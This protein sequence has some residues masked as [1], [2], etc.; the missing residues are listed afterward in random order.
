MDGNVPAKPE[1]GCLQAPVCVRCWL[2]GMPF[3]NGIISQM[4]NR[5]HGD[6]ILFNM[7]HMILKRP[8][9][10]TPPKQ[11][12]IWANCDLLICCYFP[13]FFIKCR[14]FSFICWYCVMVIKNNYV[15]MFNQCSWHFLAQGCVKSWYSDPVGSFKFQV[16][17]NYNYDWPTKINS[18]TLRRTALWIKNNG[19]NDG[20]EEK[21]L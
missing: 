8:P 15:T 9:K 4:L 7:I 6:L 16:T 20:W 5:H 2:Y 13:L 10:T 11:E 12:A 3:G 17:F 1:V 21:T 14:Y 18:K 19:Q